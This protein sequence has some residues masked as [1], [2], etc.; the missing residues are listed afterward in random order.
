ML[1]RFIAVQSFHFGLIQ[2]ISC[3]CSH[4]AYRAAISP[5]NRGTSPHLSVA[6]ITYRIHF[7]IFKNKH[8]NLIFENSDTNVI[9]AENGG[10]QRA[11]DYLFLL[12]DLAFAMLFFTFKNLRTTTKKMGKLPAM[13]IP[14]A[15]S[16]RSFVKK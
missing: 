7:L 2:Q 10:G 4:T 5:T 14:P 1:I 16:Q 12:M 3:L 11:H 6:T 9:A 15:T 8:E 13:K